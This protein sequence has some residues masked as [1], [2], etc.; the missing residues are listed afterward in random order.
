MQKRFPFFPQTKM[1][2]IKTLIRHRI[3]SAWLLWAFAMMTNAVIGVFIERHIKNRQIPVGGVLYDFGFDVLPFIPSKSLGFSLPDLCTL[4]PATFTALALNIA[5]P[6]KLAVIILRRILC[7]SAFAY[8]GRAVSVPLTLLP[9]PDSHC[10]FREKYPE[11]NIWYVSL[12]VPFGETITCNDVFFSGHTIPITC[13]MFTW[14]Y[15]MRNWPICRFFGILTSLLSLLGIIVTHFHYTVDVFYG[16]IVTCILWII[17]HKSL[18][19]PSI[20]L[21]SFRG[22]IWLEKI[23]SVDYENPPKLFGM[24]PIQFSNDPRVVW[25]FPDHKPPPIAG[26]SRTQIALLLVIALTLS[27]SWMALFTHNDT[28]HFSHS[29]PGPV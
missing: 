24:F 1:E 15:Y 23:D 29:K 18:Q 26:G 10:V 27:P 9:N 14:I 12:F 4:L 17:Y 8:L 19:C 7:I 6:P 16:F 21:T 25:S 13:A 2:F 20:L 3:F 28:H 11:S 5:F 22:I